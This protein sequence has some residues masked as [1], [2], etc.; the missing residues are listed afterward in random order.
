MT[1]NINWEEMKKWQDDFCRMA[2]VYLCCLDGSG[3]EYTNFS[4]NSH[5]IEIIKRY[6]TQ[7]R[8]ESIYKRVTE[9]DLEDQA[10]EMTEVPNLRLAACSVRYE[11]KVAGVWIVCGIITD[12]ES[13]PEFHK[14]PA[15][16]NFQYQ[17]S[18]EKFYRT[19]DLLR[20][21]LKVLI[22]LE[23]SRSEAIES[24][25]E[26]RQQELEMTSSFHRAETMTEIVSLLESNEDIE[27]VMMT[28]V[29]R[30]CAYLQ[31]SN[32]FICSVHHDTLMDLVVS[33]TLPGT[34]KIF[35][36]DT[37]LETC[38]F[39]GNPKAVV[40]S[41]GTQLGAGEREQIENLG[42][43][44]LVSLP[45]IVG[46]VARF[47]ACFAEKREKR[48]WTIDDIK[49]INDAIRI[50]QS[51]ITKKIQNNSL[52]SSFASLEAVLDNV[53]SAIYVRDITTG[54]L[55]FANRSFKKNFS[56]ELAENR[57]PELFETNIPQ[58]S[59]SGNY[60][61]HHKERQKWYDV[62]YTRVKWV[63]GR[64]VSLCAIYDVTEKKLYQR[65]I[66]QQAY[67]DFLTGLY[68]R[69]CC[70]K[71]LQKYVE[72]A[73]SNGTKGALMY[74]DL[75][76]FKHIND[77][78]GH[79]YGDVLL[80]DISKAISRIE[81]IAGSCY[82]MGG[83]EFV[84]IVPPTSYV[85]MDRILEEIKNAFATPWYLKDSDYYCTMSMGV[86]RF[87]EHGETVSELIR[88]ADVAMYEAKKSGK[89]RIAEYS[90]NIDSSS[91]RRFDLEK[92]M[93]DAIGKKAE[94]FE[95]YFQ[96]IMS[97]SIKDKDGN[98]RK[99]I[100]AEALVRWNSKS[101]GFLNPDEFIPLAE[102][103]GLITPIGNHVIRKACECC[104]VWNEAGYCDFAVAV[105]LSVVQLMQTDIVSFIK[106]CIEDNNIDPSRLVLEITERL[107]INDLARTR[108]TILDIKKL[109]VRLALDN[110]GTGYSALSSIKALPFD[111]IKIDREAIIN[112]TQDRYSQAFVKSMV[113][114][115]KTIGARI[116]VEGVE[117]EQQNK[118][119]RNMGVKYTQGFFFD[120]PLKRAAFEEKYVYK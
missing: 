59:L 118:M 70:E 14:L 110:F 25:R 77:S 96:P 85:R 16:E 66:E 11:K 35:S 21:T 5:E 103:L 113:D 15:I 114:I 10:V 72:E 30:V 27:E 40:V 56:R 20:E 117:T 12:A 2:G 44:A 97:G 87:P 58:K 13:D 115:G 43:K 62:Y 120:K 94:E 37:D 76:D 69:M 57:I 26:S 47:Y 28:V 34:S 54:V 100:G 42:I 45:V 74:L 65:R 101:L 39:I 95:V 3:R 60:E 50:L 75:D 4:G 33:W 80:Q 102:Y 53:G 31:I 8:I 32:G 79:Q 38:W 1:D 116:C 29:T 81:G 82:R 51:I 46:G 106:S 99:H 112:L 64:N 17:I 88:K 24:S 83:D 119:L 105:N 86:V 71:D 108:H 104:R 78:L 41:T 23:R 55:L 61:V 107:A 63:D 19:M 90:D 84:I 18:E 6:V 89:N 9:S 7:A 92:N 52:A 91:V 111:I 36:G 49:F 93:F 98:R 109:G 67:T 73:R 22:M 68:N 48:I